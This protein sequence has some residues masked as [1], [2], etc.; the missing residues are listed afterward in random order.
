MNLA[1]YNIGGDDPQSCLFVGDSGAGKSIAAAY[2][3]KPLY[4]GNCD[5][6]I[7]AV[8][9]WHRGEKRID[10]D[11]F[12][13][14]MDLRNKVKS[15]ESDCPYKTVVVPDPITMTSE[16]LMK[17]SFGLKGKTVFNEKT[18]QNEK[19]NK[20][21]QKGEIDLATIEEY[22]VEHRGIMDLLMDLKIAQAVHKFNI[23][24]IAHLITTQYVKMGG[25]ESHIRRD[26]VTAGR[27]IA[28]IIPIQFDEIY[29]FYTE[30]EEG[31][32][33]WKVKTFNDGITA[34]RSSFLKMPAV[35]DWTKK[36]LYEQVK[37]Y[38]IPSEKGVETSQEGEDQNVG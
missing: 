15:F 24:V 18:G 2:W 3:P 16:F 14:F 26:I 29:S 12:T 30:E 8:A 25:T 5:G 1:D 7:G 9:E 17:Y 10:F 35:I 33:R 27:K 34:A 22:G 28:A 31:K 36:D 6:R 37:K 4:M 23:I 20:G 11:I 19:L 21:K 32:N 13:N 38:Y